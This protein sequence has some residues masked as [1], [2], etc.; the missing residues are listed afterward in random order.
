MFSF[1]LG[2]FYI[3]QNVTSENDIENFASVYIY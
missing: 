2:Q 1:L 3:E